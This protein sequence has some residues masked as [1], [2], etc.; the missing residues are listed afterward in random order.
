[1][2]QIIEERFS[3]T[4]KALRELKE[5]REEMH[6]KA[7]QERQEAINQGLLSP[8]ADP[9][10]IME[11]PSDFLGYEAKRNEI[12]LKAIRDDFIGQFHL[13]NAYTAQDYDFAIREL[14]DFLEQ[15]G[16]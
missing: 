5:A 3:E 12:I 1:M 6:K 14:S 7:I 15:V 10:D 11:P 9:T 4:L 8:D 2:G 13:F 16:F